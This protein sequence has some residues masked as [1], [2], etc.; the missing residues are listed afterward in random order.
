LRADALFIRAL[1]VIR[2]DGSP[3]AQAR[4]PQFDLA[5]FDRLRRQTAIARSARQPCFWYGWKAHPYQKHGYG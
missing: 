5:S 3:S 2:A 1:S 4:A